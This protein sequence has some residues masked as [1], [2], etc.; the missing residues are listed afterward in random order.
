MGGF[1]FR[2]NGIL[3][4]T[5]KQCARGFVVSS[6]ALAR[7]GSGPVSTSLVRGL[8]GLDLYCIIDHKGMEPVVRLV[9]GHEVSRAR[10]SV[11]PIGSAGGERTP[12]LHDY[13][14]EEVDFM[15]VINNADLI[16]GIR[17]GIR[18]PTNALELFNIAIVIVEQNPL[19]RHQS[20]PHPH[21]VCNHV[22]HAPGLRPKHRFLMP[23]WNAMRN[24]DS[25]TL[26][27]PAPFHRLTYARMFNWSGNAPLHDF[28]M[29][30]VVCVRSA[31]RCWLAGAAR[32]VSPQIRA[33][34]R[35][36]A[37]REGMVMQGR[38][39]ISIA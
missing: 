21:A 2:L 36:A 32:R 13:S 30:C 9:V 24:R 7:P 35:R 1:L 38:G 25:A 37:Q 6:P 3:K 18:R 19:V 22:V 10:S 15:E 8:Q 34:L 28:A 39:E 29:M 16:V 12:R 23:V 26:D 4:Q 27:R 31:A 20:G 5:V 11:N 14:V 33:G 17:G